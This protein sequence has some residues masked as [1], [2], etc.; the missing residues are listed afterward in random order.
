[1]WLLKHELEVESKAV[2]KLK[3]LR[4]FP[5]RTGRI[6]NLESKQKHYSLKMEEF[7]RKESNRTHLHGGEPE[8]EEEE[9]RKK[10]AQWN[11]IKQ[12]IMK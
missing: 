4:K 8:F 7:L 3:K 10:K 11:M 9:V 12:R 6:I 2:A 5:H 1:M